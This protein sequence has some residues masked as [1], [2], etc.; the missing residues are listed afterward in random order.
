MNTTRTQRSE[1]SGPFVTSFYNYPLSRKLLAQICTA[2]TE[3]I[4]DVCATDL[5]RGPYLFTYARAVSD[6]S[7]VPPPYLVLDLSDVHIRAFGE[8]IASYKAQVKRPDYPDRKRIDTLRLRVLNV[9]LTAADWIA[10]TKSAIADILPMAKGEG[11]S[12]K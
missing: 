6:L 2:P 1:K 11:G 5:S 9:A 8:F 3:V 4:R 12:Q 7:P 10:P